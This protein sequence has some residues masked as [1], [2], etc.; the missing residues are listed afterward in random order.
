[1]TEAELKLKIAAYR[2]CLE[3]LETA[4]SRHSAAEDI[5]WLKN[6]A[7]ATLKHAQRQAALHVK[8]AA[9]RKPLKANGKTY[10]PGVLQ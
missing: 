2:E 4:E 1:M 10:P 7:M 5:Y 9:K 6:V 8:L 3:I